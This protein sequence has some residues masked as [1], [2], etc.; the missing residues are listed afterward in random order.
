MDDG[1]LLLVFRASLGDRAFLLAVRALAAGV[2]GVGVAFVPAFRV[3][4]VLLSLAVESLRPR[5]G[6][7]TTIYI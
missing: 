2:A 7:Q 3:A 5:P 4:G 1:P 6:F